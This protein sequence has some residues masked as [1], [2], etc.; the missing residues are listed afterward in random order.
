MKVNR[1]VLAQADALGRAWSTL[2]ARNTGTISIGPLK[3]HQ[4][5]TLV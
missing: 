3:A 5:T 4:M 1:A 2:L